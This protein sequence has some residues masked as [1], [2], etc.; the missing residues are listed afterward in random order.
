[1][2]RRYS[3]RSIKKMIKYLEKKGGGSCEKQLGEMTAKY[4]SC[5][6][7]ISGSPLLPPAL[8]YDQNCSNICPITQ[9][10][11]DNY[12]PVTEAKC[13][14]NFPDVCKKGGKRYY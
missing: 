13:V 14:N 8:R 9:A 2:G 3:N 5:K 6:M 1:M 12:F 11:C 10:K 7:N 4:N